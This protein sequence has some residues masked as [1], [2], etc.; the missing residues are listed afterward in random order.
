MGGLLMGTIFLL[1]SSEIALS[2]PL[3]PIEYYDLI[4]D[5]L[6][7]ATIYKLV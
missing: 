7:K 5:Y 2:K 4:Y 3:H 6:N 1:I